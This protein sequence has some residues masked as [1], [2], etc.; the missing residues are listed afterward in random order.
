MTSNDTFLIERA[1]AFATNAHSA[2]SQTRK[3]TGEPYAAHPAEVAKLISQTP[4]CTPEMIAAAWLHDTIEDTSTDAQTIE[5]NFGQKVCLLVQEL[6]DI[7]SMQ[8]G[9]RAQRKKIDRLHLAGASNEAK[10]IKLADLINNAESIIR[11]DKQFATVFVNEMRLL[12]EV[13]RGGDSSLWLRASKIVYGH[14]NKGF[15]SD[16]AQSLPPTAL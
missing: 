15:S 1:T 11:Y 3:Y 4:N 13:L 16:V 5:Q 7:S 10:T 14:L 12:L 2:V 8:D 6:T 9:N